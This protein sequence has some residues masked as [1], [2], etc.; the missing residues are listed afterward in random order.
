MLAATAS[1]ADDFIE[2]TQWGEMQLDFLRRFYRY[3]WGIPSHDMLNDVMNAM[4]HQLLESLFID[5]VNSLARHESDLISIDGKTSRRSG[6]ANQKPLHPVSAWASERH[7]VPGQVATDEQSNEMTA[8]PAWLKRLEVSG[9]LVTM[10]AMGTQRTIARQIV[11]AGGVIICWRSKLTT[12]RYWRIYIPSFN[13]RPQGT[14][15]M[16]P[17]Q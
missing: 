6:G 17:A 14:L 4:D 2:M 8:I 16:R 10:D 12:K 5:W 11:K 13:N 9:C 15:S 1:G 7:L 3:K